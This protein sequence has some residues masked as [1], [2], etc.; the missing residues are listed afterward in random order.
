[1]RHTECELLP[2]PRGEEEDCGAAQDGEEGNGDDGGEPA[3]GRYG[4]K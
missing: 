3:G 4:L 2:D 1:M